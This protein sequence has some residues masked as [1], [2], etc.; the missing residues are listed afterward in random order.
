MMTAIGAA[1]LWLGGFLIGVAFGRGY[2]D[3]K[4]GKR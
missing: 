1:L 2:S 3:Y 4:A